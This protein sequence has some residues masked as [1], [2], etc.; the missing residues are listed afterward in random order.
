MPMRFR[1]PPGGDVP[2]AL[3]ARRLGLT[4]TQFMMMLPDLQKRQFPP[5]DATT[6]NFDLDAIDRW[7]AA[8]YPQFSSATASSGARVAKDVA[9]ERLQRMREGG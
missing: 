4:L 3:A 6:G 1:L 5:A 2:P 9:Q 7:R 8:R